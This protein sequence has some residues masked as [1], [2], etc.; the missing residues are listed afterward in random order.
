MFHLENGGVTVHK[1]GTITITTSNP[2]VLQGCK[3]E[4]GK[5]QTVTATEN[6]EEKINN[7]YNLPSTKQSIH[8]L[9]ALAGFPIESR[10][11]KAI[12]AGN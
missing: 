12:K 6:N 4:E 5:L 3:E 9:H 1:K 11:I 8:Y 10:W 2:P 7:V